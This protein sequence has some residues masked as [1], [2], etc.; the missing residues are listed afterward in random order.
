VAVTFR[1]TRPLTDEE[2]IALSEANPAHRFERTAKGEL[3]VAPPLGM[4]GAI[5]EG[6]LFVQLRAWSKRVGLGLAVPSSAGFNLPDTSLRGPDA[7]WLSPEQVAA[8]PE[9][10]RRVFP[11]VC[12][13]AVFELMSPSDRRPPLIAKMDDY[14]ANGARLAVLIDPHRRTVE[15]YR[16]GHKPQTLVNPATV[17]LDPELPGFELELEPIFDPA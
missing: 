11:A 13:Q 1:P 4:L 2:I 8:I 7:S 16:P 5:G 10:Q 12:P 3:V 14:I 6:E 17:A 15:V 9:D